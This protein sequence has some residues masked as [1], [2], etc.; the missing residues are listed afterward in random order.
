MPI[1]FP[2]N[3]GTLPAVNE[4]VSNP[5]LYNLFVSSGA[6]NR[7]YG[8]NLIIAISDILAIH[9]TNYNNG[10]YFI[11][12]KDQWLMYK[13]NDD[14]SKVYDYKYSGNAIRVS[15]N[16]NNQLTIVDGVN[17][18]VY[19]MDRSGPD[20]VDVL[21][22]AQG[23]DIESPTDT[24]VIDTKTIIVGSTSW[25]LSSVNN[26]LVYNGNDVRV[27]D[28][29]LGKIVGCGKLNNTMYIFG[30]R[31][32]QQWVESSAATTFNFPFSLNE[33][34]QR[35]YGALYIATIQSNDDVLMFVGSDYHVRG[36]TDQGLEVF[37]NEGHANYLSKQ[38]GIE[39]SLASFLYYK[40][41][42]FYHLT[43]A[44]MGFTLCTSS[45][46]WS[47]NDKL[48]LGSTKNI[49]RDGLVVTGDNVSTLTSD[50]TSELCEIVSPVID[51]PPAILKDRFSISAFELMLTAGM[52]HVDDTEFVELLV[53]KDNVSWSNSLRKPM[54]Q[55]GQRQQIIKWFN[56][57]S[58]NQV[59]A[60]VRYYG[61]SDLSFKSLKA[62]I[63]GE[64]QNVN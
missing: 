36:I 57:F 60:R 62:N 29:S 33:Q 1:S 7:L 16:A 3:Q 43:I 38:D 26:A 20:A 18:Y 35:D 24:I 30:Q 54:P 8:L 14:P 50:H 17:A 40:G 58:T 55:T 4:Q 21:G 6:V 45:K 37:T 34:F 32:I 47:N 41:S 49:A 44:N 63:I 23:F 64:S 25:A 52:S 61:K 12:T 11:A 19:S 31:G 15:E 51:K 48:I 59:T 46:T 5:Y 22:S 27:I 9:Y 28:S 56:S 39:S 53:S 42:Y 13:L 2:I 10:S